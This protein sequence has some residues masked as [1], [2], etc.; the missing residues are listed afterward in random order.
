MCDN[1]R[2]MGEHM[3]KILNLF[4]FPLLALSLSACDW[5]YHEEVEDLTSL[6]VIGTFPASNNWTTEV[7][8][9]KKR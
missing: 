5:G 4:I 8:L 6:G 2:D 9:I 1:K 3:K 7:P